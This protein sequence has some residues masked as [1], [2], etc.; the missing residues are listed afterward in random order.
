MS[1]ALRKK[2]RELLASSHVKTN[3]KAVQ[4][5]RMAACGLDVAEIAYC[6]GVD[7]V[8]LEMHY[9]DEMTFGTARVT[10]QVGG[11][12][13]KQA[14][15]GD[16]NAGQFILRARRKWV[17]PTKIEADVTHTIE[18]KRTLMNDIVSMMQ[19]AQ[20]R[21]PVTIEQPTALPVT[22]NTPIK[23]PGRAQ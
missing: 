6:M 8:T 18:D 13:I 5:E 22:S 17:T 12:M 23:S 3:G 15:K 11:A 10:A 1:G 20:K 19:N 21:T 14:L 2:E 16:T 4:V 9:K 7:A